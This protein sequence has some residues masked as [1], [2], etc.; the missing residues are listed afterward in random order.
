MEDEKKSVFEQQPE[1]DAH[2]DTS[3]SKEVAQ[4]EIRKKE[5]PETIQ[6]ETA[7]IKKKSLEKALE[8]AKKKKQ[9]EVKRLYLQ[10]KSGCNKD[11]CYNQYCKNNIYG[12]FRPTISI[13][14]S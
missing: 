4:I 9:Q 2:M 7:D 5:E 1:Q 6:I 12:K 11:V 10:V 14:Y 8:E 3:S 13:F